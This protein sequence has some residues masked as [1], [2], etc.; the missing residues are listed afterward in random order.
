[1]SLWRAYTGETSLDKLIGD[2]E[3]FLRGLARYAL[4]FQTAWYTSDEDDLFQEACI[5]L[6]TSMW[7]WDRDK[8]RELAE[9]VVWNIG[10]RLGNKIKSERADRRHP[11]ANHSRKVDIWSPCWDDNTLCMEAMIAGRG[12]N[13][14]MV[15]AVREA[16]DRADKELTDLARSLMLALVMND[17][18]LAGAARDLLESEEIIKRFGPDERH[19]RYELRRRVMP[20]IFN[21]LSPMHIMPE[22][23]VV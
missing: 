7:D 20:E 15:V 22:N 17:G 10:A 5:W 13:P 19:L 12:P 6:N 18:N 21:F 4:R 23:S 11:D 16:L 2:Q 3:H 1:V 14:E 8:G 9:Y